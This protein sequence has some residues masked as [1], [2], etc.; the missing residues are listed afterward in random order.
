MN[1]AMLMVLLLLLLL[2][3]V[4]LTC[5]YDVEP[6]P[7][8]RATKGQVWPIPYKRDVSEKFFVIRA[9]SFEFQ[10]SGSS[11]LFIYL[12]LVSVGVVRVLWWV[13]VYW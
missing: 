3:N 6:G 4:F 10:V 5:S 1:C 8:V 7:K 12:F 13:L 9:S 2:G 11:I